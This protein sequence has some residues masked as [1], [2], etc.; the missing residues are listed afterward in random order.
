METN[1]SRNYKIQVFEISK[2][3]D[4]NLLIFT[5]IFYISSERASKELPDSIRMKSVRYKISP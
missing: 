1:L 2:V 4:H 5:F 3:K